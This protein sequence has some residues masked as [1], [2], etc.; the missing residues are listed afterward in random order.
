MTNRTLIE[1]MEEMKGEIYCYPKE[2]L[3]TITD[4]K[5]GKIFC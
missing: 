1:I 3:W 2:S 5:T 4:A